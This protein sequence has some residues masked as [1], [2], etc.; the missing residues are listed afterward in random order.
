MPNY[1]QDNNEFDIEKGR[2]LAGFILYGFLKKQI[3]DDEKQRLFKNLSAISLARGSNPQAVGIAYGDKLDNIEKLAEDSDSGNDHDFEADKPSIGTFG[4]EF[5]KYF[6][7]EWDDATK[8]FHETY[9]EIA[10]LMKEKRNKIKFPN[11][12]VRDYY[13]ALTVM[14]DDMAS[15][16][17]QQRIEK[18][19]MYEYTWN[20]MV[21]MNTTTVRPDLDFD[22]GEFKACIANRDDM[23]VLSAFSDHSILEAMSGSIRVHKKFD[24]HIKTGDV[25]REELIS[26]YEKQYDK[27][28]KALSITKD[29]YNDL[30]NAKATENNF[31]EYTNGPRGYGHV[32]DNVDSKIKLLKAGWPAADID[33]VSRTKQVI[34]NIKHTADEKLKDYERAKKEYETAEKN[35][36]ANLE[37]KKR[38]ADRL[39]QQ[40]DVRVK[41]YN[42]IKPVWE[43]TIKGPLTQESRQEKLTNIENVLRNASEEINSS[44]IK[45]T[46]AKI[47]ERTN[48][49][50]PE[51]DKA[52]MSGGIDDMFSALDSVDPMLMSSSDQFKKFKAALKSLKEKAKNLDPNDQERVQ[53]YTEQVKKTVK[54]GAD[55]Q[56]YKRHQLLGPDGAKHKRSERE[57]KRVQTVDNI[58]FKLKGLVVPGTGEKIIDRKNPQY[59]AYTAPDADG[60]LGDLVVSKNEN[61]Y[62]KYIR[63]HTGR[64]AM[65]GSKEQ[66]VDSLSKAIGVCVMKRKKPRTK[67][68]EKNAK[69]FA[70]SARE[71]FQLDNLKENELAGFLGKPKELADTIDKLNKDIYGIRMSNYDEYLE[72][73]RL[74]YQNLEEPVP[75]KNTIY[76]KLYNAVKKAA[77]LPESTEDIDSE[78]MINEIASINHDIVNA[79]M[80]QLKAQGDKF[81][82][83]CSA[84]MLAMNM[85]GETSVKV[86]G[87]VKK[88]A[89][90]VNRARG[91][92]EESPG[93][94]DLGHAKYIAVDEYDRDRLENRINRRQKGENLRELDENLLEITA[95]ELKS[96]NINKDNIMKQRKNME[97]DSKDIKKNGEKRK[98]KEAPVGKKVVPA[99]RPR[100]NSIG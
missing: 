14:A 60:L 81:G 63:L 93:A 64:G 9:G 33:Y 23:S 31:D 47:H 96:A 38:E 40:Y 32:L 20:M 1:N 95:E 85:V 56:K 87:F 6:G 42:L 76:E 53:E 35:G 82:K 36:A 46:I 3:P 28:K 18:D 7:S 22:T 29:D 49:P 43:N 39:K 27:M 57:K 41:H 83:K 84:S 48:E 97:K 75:N 89:I 92:T 78:I 30:K 4:G 12:T 61:E 8:L 68:D 55:Y 21:K 72:N 86:K 80:A 67:F 34:E 37:E 62:D 16:G 24:D 91:V 59:S 98:P 71:Q 74:L 19:P 100:R 44:I 88:A 50:L 79:S 90:M 45:F 2:E 65:N 13:D 5:N 25:S 51:A 15:G 69:K 52:L 11:D 94:F 58:L 17:W 99:S 54:L 73:M 77:H 66:M 10:D 26:E 70:D